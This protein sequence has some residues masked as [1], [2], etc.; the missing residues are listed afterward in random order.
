M[1]ELWRRYSVKNGTWRSADLRGREVVLQEIASA[2]GKTLDLKVEDGQASLVLSTRAGSLGETLR[3]ASIDI[4][5]AGELGSSVADP[6]RSDSTLYIIPA[7]EGRSWHINVPKDGRTRT[8]ASILVSDANQEVPSADWLGPELTPTGEVP[9]AFAT[10]LAFFRNLGG[11]L[12]WLE[13]YSKPVA[14]LLAVLG[15]LTISFPVLRRIYEHVAMPTESFQIGSLWANSDKRR[16]SFTSG[17][18]SSPAWDSGF[19]GDALLALSGNTI[20]VSGTAVGRAD[21][22]TNAPIEHVLTAN[23]CLYV[24]SVWLSRYQQYG[25]PPGQSR[26][27]SGLPGGSFDEKLERLT[28]V[29]ASPRK[30]VTISGQCQQSDHGDPDHYTDRRSRLQAQRDQKSAAL[31]AVRREADDFDPGDGSTHSERLDHAR[32]ALGAAS[33]ALDANEKS[34]YPVC[35]RATVWINAIKVTC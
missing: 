5:A 11:V 10:V 17:E 15:F 20:R 3:L 19:N 23:Q 35:P 13:R 2:N 9:S 26:E 33:R 12:D 29:T 24:K 32:K 28:G 21:T 27:Q 31:D 8:I 22:S 34:K 6:K 7:A 4:S 1:G 16:F 18:Y 30:G 14:I 25:P